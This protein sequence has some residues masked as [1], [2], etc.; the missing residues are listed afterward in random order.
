[1]FHWFLMDELFFIAG[2]AISKTTRLSFPLAGNPSLKTRERFSPRR[3][4][5][6]TG[7]AGMTDSKHVKMTLVFCDV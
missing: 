1:M 2:A 6:E 3:V 4:A 7:R 5:E